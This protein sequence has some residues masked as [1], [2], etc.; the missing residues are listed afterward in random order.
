MQGIQGNAW[1]W[2]QIARGIQGNARGCKGVGEMC[3]EITG[4]CQGNVWIWVQT[5]REMQWNAR[6]MKWSLSKVL[7]KCRSEECWGMYGDGCNEPGEYRECRAMQENPGNAGEHKGVHAKCQGN[8]GECRRVPGEHMGVCAKC[9]E[10]AGECQGKVW[11]SQGDARGT[12]RSGCKIPGKCRRMQR[13]ARGMH[14]SVYQVQWNAGK[15]NGI[16]GERIGV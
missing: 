11:E 7:G 10:N 8:A 6:G 9:Q 2:V 3:Q 12:Y 14:W 16:T 13:N 5:A 4:G 1:E 15:F